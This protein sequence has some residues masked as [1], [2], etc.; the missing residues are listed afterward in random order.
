MNKAEGKSAFGT[1]T[2]DPRSPAT[3]GTAESGGGLKR[4]ATEL[5][6][7]R[8]ERSEKGGGSR[9]GGGP[10]AKHA[11][12]VSRVGPTD[13]HS[14]SAVPEEAG[15]SLSKGIYKILK[16]VHP[17]TEISKWGLAAP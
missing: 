13:E 4:A 12:L 10:A 14:G 11:K 7:E 3:A 6:E 15:I 16:Q 8:I 9:S 17:D 5:E 2:A 1:P